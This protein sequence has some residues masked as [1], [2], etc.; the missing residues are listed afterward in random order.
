M[1]SSSRKLRNV[2]ELYKRWSLLI[3]WQNTSCCC[4]WR[5]LK[6][7]GGDTWDTEKILTY[8]FRDTGL[9]IFHWG[10]RECGF[11]VHSHFLIIFLSPL[12]LFLGSIMT[13]AVILINDNILCTRVVIEYRGRRTTNDLGKKNSGLGDPRKLD[14]MSALRFQFRKQGRRCY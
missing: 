2:S 3:I 4:L 14:K 6:T 12:L 7:S 13:S 9:A 5:S 11:F 8:L 10:N 1:F